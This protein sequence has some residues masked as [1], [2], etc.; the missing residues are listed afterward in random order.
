MAISAYMLGMFIGSFALGDL[1]DRIGRRHG[2]IVS[3]M[4]LSIGG[5]LNAVSVNYEMFVATRFVMGFGAV[6]AF[7]ISFILGKIYPYS[8]G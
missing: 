7:S 1:A 8:Y 5:S 2:I 6:S 4:I 3:L